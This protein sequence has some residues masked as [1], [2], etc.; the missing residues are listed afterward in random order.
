MKLHPHPFL[1]GFFALLLF[2]QSGAILQA[3]DNEARLEIILVEAS[4]GEGGVDSSLRPYADTLQRLFRFK[5][6]RQV[7]QR[8]MRLTVPG[9]STVSLEG[10]QSL[11]LE[12]E[13]SGGPGLVAQL[14]WSRGSQRLL[15]TRLQLRSGS[16][17]VLGGPRSGD[18]GGSYLL[19]LRLR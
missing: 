15:H 10:G 14:T 1:L 3:R 7:N 18:A 5:S 11:R 19:I 12:A 17:A 2:G 9:N 8:S 13:G 16:P 6:Y 4:N